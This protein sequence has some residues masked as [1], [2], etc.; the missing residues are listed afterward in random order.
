MSTLDYDISE[1]DTRLGKETHVYDGQRLEAEDLDTDGSPLED[2]ESFE[3]ERYPGDA[4]ITKVYPSQG[5]TEF[6]DPQ[7]QR[8]ER[9]PT[10]SQRTGW[11]HPTKRAKPARKP[12]AFMPN[13][14]R[15]QVKIQWPMPPA[16][17]VEAHEKAMSA[18]QAYDDAIKA[19]RSLPADQEAET[20]RT[21]EVIAEAV[22]AGEPT[23][24][25]ERTDWASEAVV[26][27][28]KHEEAFREADHAA[29]AFGIIAK[30]HRNEWAEA[31][32]AGIA[33]ARK[34][35]RKAM[36]EAAEAMKA[37]RAAV[38]AGHRLAIGSGLFAPDWHQSGEPKIKPSLALGDL[39]KLVALATSE[40]PVISGEYLT[41]EAE[42]EPPLHTRKALDHKAELGSGWDQHL[43]ARIE[44]AEGFAKTHF[45]PQHLRA[46]Y[47]RAA[48]DD[49]EIAGL[50]AAKT[51]TNREA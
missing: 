27:D 8:G 39:E 37:W 42:L 13:R 12:D 30:A 22:R 31:V 20:K 29:K 25:V 51:L 44:A 21:R 17:V 1:L 47:L 41:T 3:A 23:P 11:I 14:L 43:L 33:P 16:A 2:N 4:D 50:L 10:V 48:Q 18:I 38:D 6:T 7:G 32:F 15:E 24:Q 36:L 35:A 45:T 19:I 46:E 49:R 5:H 28:I 9:A 26:R 40:D 34:K